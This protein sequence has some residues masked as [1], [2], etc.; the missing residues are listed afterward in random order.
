[1][2][3]KTG[4]AIALLVGMMGIILWPPRWIVTQLVPPIAC[5]Q[6]VYAVSLAERVVALTIDDGPDLRVGTANSTV[7]ILDIL[8]RYNAEHPGQAAHAT[9]F[10]MGNS[11]Q[12][13]ERVSRDQHDALVS[14]VVSEGHEI[15]NHMAED[16]ASILLGQ[17]F[18]EVLQATH[19]RLAAYAA[20]PSSQ[21]PRVRWLR[22][23]VG[24]CDRAMLA[25]V[26]HQADYVMADGRPQ[27]VLGSLWPY[28]TIQPWP[29]FSRWFIRQNV[30]PGA[31]IVLHDGGERGDR[32]VQVLPQL[33]I[34][35]AKQ[36]YQV[37]PLSQLTP[38]GNP[39]EARLRLPDPLDRLRQTLIIQ[40]EN[41]R[42]RIRNLT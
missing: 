17:Q 36:H 6:A 40:L 37:V 16:R 38:M 32:T 20:S 30:Q 41:V 33:L 35:L 28:D 2:R 18:G 10:L 7:Q 15:G 23:G 24:W 8:R 9:F 4:M 13:R 19:Q 1:M 12:A 42:L 14:R 5:P 31:I 26:A 39:I 21:Y 25:T 22:P 29:R 27:V 11:V 34:A 3:W